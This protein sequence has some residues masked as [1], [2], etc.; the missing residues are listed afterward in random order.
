MNIFDSQYFSFFTADSELS[1]CEDT[2]PGIVYVSCLNTTEVEY[3][4]YK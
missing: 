2:I 3:L 1:E 4:F